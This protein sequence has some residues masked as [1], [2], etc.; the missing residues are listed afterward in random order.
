M[1]IVIIV[2]KER[3]CNMLYICYT[4]KPVDFDTDPN[5]H[6]SEGASRELEDVEHWSR[7]CKQAYE[8]Q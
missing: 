8:Q 1:R 2:P 5:P 4:A 3:V 7:V 6:Q